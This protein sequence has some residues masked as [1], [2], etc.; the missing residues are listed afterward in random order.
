MDITNQLSSLETVV[1]DCLAQTRHLC[2][3]RLL[4]LLPVPA[5]EMNVYLAVER[6]QHAGLVDAYPT[7]GLDSPRY[8]L[9]SLTEQG[10]AA[11]GG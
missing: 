10:R 4:E 6:L 11:V 8:G 9:I 1:L 5:D 2:S 3:D 7:S